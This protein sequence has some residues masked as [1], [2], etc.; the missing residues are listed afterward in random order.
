GI[1][2]LAELST[3]ETVL[4]TRSGRD[5]TLEYPELRM[6]PELVDQVNAV[7]DGEIVAF[8]TDGKNSFEALQQRMN[9]TGEREIKRLAKQI[10]VS[11]VAVDVL[12]LDGRDTTDL[13][14]EDRRDLLESVVEQ[15][16]RLQITTHVVGEGRSFVEAAR[17]L[18][19]EGVVAKRLGS[20]YQPGRRADAWR[21][22]KLVNRQDCVILGRTPGLRGRADTFGAL[23]VGALDHGEGRWIGQVGSGY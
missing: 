17:G 5:V 6:V 21:K 20:K 2:C 12:W 13:L 1:R 8:D 18:G 23:L 3:G 9:L 19:L 11:L 7:I 15:D 16:H 10:P 22:I 14:L 4:G